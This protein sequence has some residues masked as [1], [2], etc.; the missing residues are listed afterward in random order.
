MTD[1][2][3]GKVALVT[4]SSSGIGAATAKAMAAAGARVAVNSS[5]STETGEALAAELED[6]IYVRGDIADP[7]QAAALV[8]QVVE[9]CGRLDVLVNNAGTTA[10]IPH[11]DF[12]AA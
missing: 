9:R 1:K 4:G 8:E 12:D 3:H 10:V 2:L 6:A 11:H 5:K 7:V